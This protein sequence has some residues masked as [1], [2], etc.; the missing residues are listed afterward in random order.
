MLATEREPLVRRVNAGPRKLTLCEE[1]NAP[2]MAGVDPEG[3]PGWLFGAIIGRSPE[4]GGVSERLEGEQHRSCQG[5][6]S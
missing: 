3:A 4:L 2:D 6:S 5:S 1:S